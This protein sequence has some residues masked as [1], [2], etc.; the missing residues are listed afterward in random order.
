MTFEAA[1]LFGPQNR[2]IGSCRCFGIAFQIFG[3]YAPTF[4][5][6]TVLQGLAWLLL[7]LVLW[8]ILALILYALGT[9]FYSVVGPPG[10]QLRELYDSFSGNSYDNA[11]GESGADVSGDDVFDFEVLW[12]FGNIFVE[13][14]AVMI[15]FIAVAI[16]LSIMVTS[17]FQGA[18]IQAVAHAYA[19]ESPSV[20]QCLHKGWKK[21]HLVACYRILL[22]LAFGLVYLIFGM[23]LPALVAEMSPAA[24]AKLSTLMNLILHVASAVASAALFAGPAMI[25]VD[26]KGVISGFYG[27][28]GLTRNHLCFVFCTRWLFMLMFTG[29]FFF[30]FLVGSLLAV[31]DNGIGAVI[32]TV[33]AIVFCLLYYPLIII[34]EVVLYFTLRIRD[35]GLTQGILAQQLLQDGS[36]ESYNVVPTLQDQESPLARATLLQDEE[37]PAFGKE[38]A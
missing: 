11:F 26:S 14:L 5:A 33:I 34:L 4:L 22:A 31:G 17:T 30:L 28:L 38:I 16:M 3:S 23:G 24:G 37:V 21:K 36:S 29:A 7:A 12:Q 15:I 8:S 6:L 25:M 35:E 18:K 32:I 10:R 27:T 9:S 20:I 1:S 13:Y 19:G 2:N